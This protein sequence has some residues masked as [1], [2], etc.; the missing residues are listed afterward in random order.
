M[1]KVADQTSQ[2]RSESLVTLTRSGEEGQ[3]LTAGPPGEALGW[4]SEQRQVF[5]CFFFL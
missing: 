5:G 2:S 1:S 4:V 3:R